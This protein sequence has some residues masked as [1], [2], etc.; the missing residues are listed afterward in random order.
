MTDH[1]TDER[2]TAMSGELPS[3]DNYP[4]HGAPRAVMAARYLEHQARNWLGDESPGLGRDLLNGAAKEIRRLQAKLVDVA[5]PAFVERWRAK[6]EDV[7]QDVAGE[8]T[9]AGHYSAAN[10]IEWLATVPLAAFATDEERICDACLTVTSEGT[11]NYICESCPTSPGC[12]S[13]GPEGQLCRLVPGHLGQHHNPGGGASSS[14]SWS[15][16][17]RTSRKAER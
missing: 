10:C 13:D 16:G 15:T 7:V 11:W 9:V 6:H 8:L 2:L 3:P 5:V 12:G 1:L 14:S 4:L 17:W